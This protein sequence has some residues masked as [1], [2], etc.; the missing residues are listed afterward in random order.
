MRFYER[1]LV[2]I[3]LTAVMF[4]GAS[5]VVQA[6]GLIANWTMN[7]SVGSATVQDESGNGHAGTLP[8]A[9]GAT[10]TLGV[11]GIIGTA[12]S[13]PGDATGSGAGY[14]ISVP[15][16][17]AWCGQTNMT[18]S[19]WVY[20]NAAL[21]HQ[22]VFDLYTGTAAT[23]VLSLGVPTIPA[24]GGA[25][26]VCPSQASEGTA[27]FTT[28]TWYLVTA[29]WNGS[30][31]IGAPNPN[32]DGMNAQGEI[33]IYIDGVYE[34]DTATIPAA[35]S[36]CPYPNNSN[37]TT[38]LGLGGNA[39]AGTTQSTQ[40]WNGKLNDLGLWNV[41]LSDAQVAALYNVPMYN[42]HTGAV[43]I[44][45]ELDGPVV[46]ALQHPSGHA[47][48]RRGRRRQHAELGVRRQ[49]FAW[50]G[51]QRRSDRRAVL[52]PT[53]L[54]RRRSRD[55]HPDARTRH[56][57]PAGRRHARLNG[58]RLAEA[59]IDN[60]QTRPL[61]RRAGEGWGLKDARP[62]IPHFLGHGPFRGGNRLI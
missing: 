16:S 22:Y 58:L 14:Y 11:P 62:A 36:Y 49:R 37:T 46:H 20:F 13:L 28:N 47:R 6:N 40:E 7:D 21:K 54:Q 10:A 8:T 4:V 61:S 33:R 30:P 15:A 1:F 42:G 43:A 50:H 12:V 55:V 31:G 17:S 57:G 35:G 2:L 52:R 56:A 44:R 24:W 53:R 32:G 5:C 51:R 38:P 18:Q 23:S 60:R 41:T 48:Y 19:A 9:A 25:Y 27:G 29:T 3:S 39:T 45:R 34:H 59:E 26:Y